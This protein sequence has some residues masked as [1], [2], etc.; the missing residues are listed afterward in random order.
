MPNTVSHGA[1]EQLVRKHRLRAAQPLLGRLED[2]IDRAVEVARLGE[3]AR[4][5]EQ[6]GGVAVVTAGM[7]H[8]GLGRFV[9]QLVR[10]HDRQCVHVGAQPDR[11]RA[12]A[13]AQHTDDTGATDCTVHLDAERFQLSCHDVRGAMLLE[14]ELGVCVE[15]LADRGQLRMIGLDAVER[16][17]ADYRNPDGGKRNPGAPHC[18]AHMAVMRSRG[19]LANPR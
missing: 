9:W 14:A 2:E 19:M 16:A 10:F 13:L 12:V 7:H 5:T 18:G 4:R 6:H 17:H 15:I 11:H 1:R 8:A 3:I